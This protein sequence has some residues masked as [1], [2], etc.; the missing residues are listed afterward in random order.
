MTVFKWALYHRPKNLGM[1]WK[2][3]CNSPTE[4]GVEAIDQEFQD[5]TKTVVWGNSDGSPENPVSVWGCS[6]ACFLP[7]RSQEWLQQKA[8]SLGGRTAHSSGL[9]GVR[10]FNGKFVRI[11]DLCKDDHDA[12]TSI[13]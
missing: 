2:L 8:E 1:E 4:A 7:F 5:L 6:E 10:L 11:D 12:R 3:F 13:P 9:P